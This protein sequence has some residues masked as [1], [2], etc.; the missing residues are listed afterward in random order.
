MCHP[1]YIYRLYFLNRT[2][3]DLRLR[4]PEDRNRSIE[5]RLP[6]KKIGVAHVLP[7]VSHTWT[8]SGALILVGA[9]LGWGD[10][11]PRAAGEAAKCQVHSHHRGEECGS[12]RMARGDRGTPPRR[13]PDVEHTATIIGERNA[14]R[15][16]CY[17]DRRC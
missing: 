10:S 15:R 16:K 9:R 5:Q 8:P 7:F 11:V 17:G 13:L 6:M 12:H 1:N 14:A 3:Q 2:V 4:V